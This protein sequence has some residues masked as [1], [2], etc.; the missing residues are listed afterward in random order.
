MNKI[1]DGDKFTVKSCT[2]CG[3]S[4]NICSFTVQCE[5]SIEVR[6]VE[7]TLSTK[8]G[9]QYVVSHKEYSFLLCHNPETELNIEDIEKVDSFD[10]YFYFGKYLK[11]E[12]INIFPERIDL[13]S[14]WTFRISG[15][16]GKKLFS[17][18]NLAKDF[19]DTDQDNG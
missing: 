8:T 12:I 10:A 15:S 2:I 18:Y 19:P 13:D 17:L 4:G 1:E 11:D 9:E 7:K 14:D 16:E 6:T 3:R 5:A